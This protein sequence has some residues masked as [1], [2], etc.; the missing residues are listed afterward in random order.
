[1]Y[2]IYFLLGYLFWAS[3]YAMVGSLFTSEQEATQVVGV[4]VIIFVIPLAMAIPLAESPNSLV[5]KTLS[6]RNL[7]LPPG[8]FRSGKSRR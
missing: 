1:M 2:L 4:L 8:R 3:F 7:S 6:Y 5:A